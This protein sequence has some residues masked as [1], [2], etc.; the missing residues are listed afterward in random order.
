MGQ[1]GAPQQESKESCVWREP[2]DRG[3]PRG[4]PQGCPHLSHSPV[5]E[6]PVGS[7]LRARTWRT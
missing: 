1:G 2:R 5:E 3:A 6:Q 4:S 7:G